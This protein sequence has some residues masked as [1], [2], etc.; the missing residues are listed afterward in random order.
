MPNRSMTLLK[1]AKSF[2]DRDT[3]EKVTDFDCD[4]KEKMT[5]KA[6]AVFARNLLIN[7]EAN[8]DAKTV[9]L[10][11]QNCGHHCISKALIEKAKEEYS[12]TNDIEK[13]IEYMNRSGIGGKGSYI[14]NGKII[15]IYDKCYCGTARSIRDMPASYCCCSEG[16][17]GK[18]FSEVLEKE[19]EVRKRKTILDGEKECEFEITVHQQ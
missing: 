13:L 11:M 2:L 10:I 19:V 3:Y 6:Q 17:F 12:K 8:C 7:L 14:K 16:W 1:N 4:E 18:L 15:C 5:T 9:R